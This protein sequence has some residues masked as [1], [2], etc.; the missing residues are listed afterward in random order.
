MTYSIT[1]KVAAAGTPTAQGAPSLVGHMWYTL[2]DANG[3]SYDYGWAPANHGTADG[4]GRVYT[5]DSS[6]YMGRAACW[7]GLKSTR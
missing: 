1:V 3:T 2:T 7:R 6:N 4:P 5:D